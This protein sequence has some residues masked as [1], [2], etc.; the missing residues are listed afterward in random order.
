MR[1]RD[2]FSN[3]MR[4]PRTGRI[5]P[6]DAE[7]L[8][9]TGR[10]PAHPELSRLLAAAA[11]PPRARE[12]AGMPAAVAAFEEAAWVDRPVAVPR[13]R[14][15]LRPLA[16]AGAVVAML[17][18]GVAVAA[19]TGNLPGGPVPDRTTATSAPPEATRPAPSRGP[20][21]TPAAAPQPH[22]GGPDRTPGPAGPTA[23]GLCRAWDAQRRNPNGA[24]MASEA[25]RGLA[26]AAGGESRIPAFCAALLEPSR[27]SHPTGK[28]PARPAP[29]TA[30]KG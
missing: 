16:A 27:P 5:G 28:G 24:P 26:A 18:G 8:L 1:G 25:R 6:D 19:E 13:R 7:L 11:S 14:R 9:A 22:A 15:V 30:K 12:L 21:R 4:T 3:A 17:A 23:T 10:T 2:A 20:S 29:A